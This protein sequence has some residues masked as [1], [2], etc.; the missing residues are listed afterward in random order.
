MSHVESQALVLHKLDQHFSAVIH[1]IHYY[2]QGPV[3]GAGRVM[4]A[5]DQER[6]IEILSSQS[7]HTLAFVPDTLL[8]QDRQT[9]MWWR[10]AG[11]A[12]LGFSA[13]MLTAHLPALVFCLH[14]G[15][16]KVAALRSQERPTPDSK[17]YHSGFPN[18]SESGSWCSGGNRLPDEPNQGHMQRVQD[19][20]LESPFTHGG[21]SAIKDES[22]VM[23]F[24][25]NAR[26][27]KPFPVRRLLPMGKTLGD[28]IKEAA[29]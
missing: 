13:G 24:W 5:S 7:N 1:D 28:W 9:L 21:G 8:A 15:N 29:K 18:T 25:K 4:S 19:T 27:A 14:K 17:L 3:M 22:N 11:P 2:D 26:R 10:P 23:D 12:Q 6:L 16:L 20:F